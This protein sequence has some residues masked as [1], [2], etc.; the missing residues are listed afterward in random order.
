MGLRSRSARCAGPGVSAQRQQA[1]AGEKDACTASAEGDAAAAVL[2]ELR[3]RRRERR[4]GRLEWFDIAYKAY[5]VVLFGGGAVLWLT[6][7]VGDE[8]VTTGL[9]DVAVDGRGLVSLV[10]ATA[11][12]VGLRSGARGGPLAIE[13]ADVAHVLLAP[14]PRRAVLRLPFVQRL[15][16]AVLAGLSLGAICGRLAAQRLPGSPWAWAASCAAAGALIGVLWCGAALVA[17][18]RPRWIVGGIGVLVVA[19]HAADAAGTVPAPLRGIGAV[20]MSA[21][22]DTD[23]VPVDAPWIAVAIAVAVVLVMLAAGTAT[24]ER[25]SL[26]ALA[27]RSALVGQL[28]FAATMQDLRTVVLLRRQLDEEHPRRIPWIRRPDRAGTAPVSIRRAVWRRDVSGLLRMPAARL[29]RMAVLSVAWGIGIALMMRGTTP[30][31]VAAGLAGF[32]LGMEAIEPLSQEVDHADRC[33]QLPI[34]RGDLML[35]HL[36]APAAMLVPFAVV[37]ALVAA[38]ASGDAAGL[39]VPLLIVSVPGVWAAAAG[40]VVSAVRDAPDPV[41]AVRGPTSIAM[42][43]V[44]G[45]G[46]AV[47][48]VLPPAVSTLGIVMVLF[49]RSAA[50]SGGAVVGASLRAAAGALVLVFLVSQ[51]VRLRDRAHRSTAA[52][53]AEGRAAS[54][55]GSGGM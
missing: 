33:D 31:V 18:S 5:L 46:T 26:E 51:W 16:T 42:P 14:V 39:V 29:A 17:H 15:R 2:R 24:L 37:G 34:E 20:A 3:M 32:V 28:R 6:G 40:A 21:M 13:A 22:A 7:L 45:L 50:E 23:G 47:R 25:M 38:L 49:V 44:T 4:L 10:A 52:F 30:A 35:H 53:M 43:E 36:A 55:L 19:W 48:A 54:R 8:P 1:P 41:A 9:A 11:V 27:R 12:F